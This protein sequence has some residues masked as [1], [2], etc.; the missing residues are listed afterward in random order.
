MLLCNR[1]LKTR[2]SVHVKRWIPCL[3]LLGMLDGCGFKPLYQE[4]SSEIQTGSASSS[5]IHIALISNREGQIL[6]NALQEEMLLIQ[7]P[8]KQGYELQVKID[9][10]KVN[11]GIRVDTSASRANMSV[12]A[13]FS[14]IEPGTQK[15]ALQQT[16]RRTASYHLDDASFVTLAAEEDVTKRLMLS[17]SEDIAARLQLFFDQAQSRKEL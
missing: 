16:V 17:V 12:V 11:L 15:V 9:I 1:W 7:G 2:V 5:N 8:E 10:S 3:M 14:L 13:T 4:R 6:R